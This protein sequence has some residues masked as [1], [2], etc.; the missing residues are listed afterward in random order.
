MSFTKLVEDYKD[1]GLKSLKVF[2]EEASQEEFDKEVKKV[3]DKATGK[4][5]NKRI[6]TPTVLA[7]KDQDEIE[8]EE[9]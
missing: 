4:I 8:K 6:A 2:F 7:T 9:D 1:N 5:R 3:E